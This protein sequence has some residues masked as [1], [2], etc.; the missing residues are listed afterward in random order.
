MSANLQDLLQ[1]AVQRRESAGIAN[2]TR[3]LTEEVRKEEERNPRGLQFN[4]TIA[5]RI[6]RGIHPGQ[7]SNGTIRAIAY[8]AGVGDEEAFTAAGRKAPGLPFQEEL[9]PGIDDLTPADRKAA[10]SIL[11]QLIAQRHEINRLE[12]ALRPA[13]VSDRTK[14]DNPLLPRISGQKIRKRS[15]K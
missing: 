14:T 9:P 2:S 7:L 1:R 10:L 8:L 4:P 11:R 13:I 15:S 12:D 5:S 6:L 3:A